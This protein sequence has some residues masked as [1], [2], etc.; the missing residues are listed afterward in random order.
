MKEAGQ[1]KVAMDQRH[2]LSKELM[3]TGDRAGTGELYKMLDTINELIEKW[4]D[5]TELY[6]T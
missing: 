2:K 6:G 1:G 4:D 3:G 5:K